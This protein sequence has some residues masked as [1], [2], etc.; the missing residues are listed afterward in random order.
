MTVSDQQ[1][2]QELEQ[3]RLDVRTLLHRCA[4]GRLD[5]TPVRVGHLFRV[6]LYVGPVDREPRDQLANRIGELMARVVAMPPMALADLQQEIR[7]TIH[8][9][10]E[11]LA[12]HEEFLVAHDMDVVA[13]LARE[14]AIELRQWLAG[15]GIDEESRHSIQEVV[16]RRAFDRPGLAQRLAWLEDLLGHDPGVRSRGAETIRG[17]PVD[18]GGHPG[19][20]SADRR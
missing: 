13:C 8:V 11:N 12:E 5:V 20:R 15:V 9:A 1:V 2:A 10:P 6:G 7:Q 3:R 4:H 16:S 19:D 18:R 14:L 17:T